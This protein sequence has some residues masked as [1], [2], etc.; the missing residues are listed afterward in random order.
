VVSGI[1]DPLEAMAMCKSPEIRRA[2][3]ELQGDVHGDR[4]HVRRAAADDDRAAEHPRV[5]DEAELDP[6]RSRSG[7][8]DGDWLL[9][10]LER[11]RDPF[12]QGCGPRVSND[13]ATSFITT[14]AHAPLS[15]PFW[16]F[17][18]SFSA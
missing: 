11:R 6:R 18:S 12:S 17:A 16:S 13:S 1:S 5:V 4:R 8:A 14:Q 3:D 7:T 10:G 9:R 2:L 15:S